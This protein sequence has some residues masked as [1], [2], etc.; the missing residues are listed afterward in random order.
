M[1]DYYF[2]QINRDVST[3]SYN[4]HANVS[5]SVPNTES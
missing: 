1:A 2:A 4:G 5:E 3:K